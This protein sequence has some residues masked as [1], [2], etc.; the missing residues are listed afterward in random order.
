[1]YWCI[2]AGCICDNGDVGIVRINLWNTLKRGSPSKIKSFVEYVEEIDNT[3]SAVGI[4]IHER[5]YISV[6]GHV[7]STCESKKVYT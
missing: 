6:K 3:D 5:V 2:R 4:V 1:M 7:Y